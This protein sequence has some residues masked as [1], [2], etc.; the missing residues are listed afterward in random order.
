[1]ALYFYVTYHVK[2]VIKLNKSLLDVLSFTNK[3]LIFKNAV[4]TVFFKNFKIKFI[5][6]LFFLYILDHL[7]R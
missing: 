1:M 7:I 4:K 5:K 2:V 3:I 6:N